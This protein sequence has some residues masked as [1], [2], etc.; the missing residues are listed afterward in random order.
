M[1]QVINLFP[2]PMFHAAIAPRA[3]TGV[4]KAGWTSYIMRRF[5]LEGYLSN[6]E[7]Y[8]IT[9]VGGVP[10][11][12]IAMIMSP[13]SKK[14]SLKAARAGGSGAA[15]LGKGPQARF[16]ALMSEG[17]PFTQVWGMVGHCP[18]FC[19]EMSTDIA[20]TS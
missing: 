20:A 8:A 10:P 13:L 4:L 3:H 15:P 1:K 12:I 17:A 11:M 6:C 14:Y 7:K 16:Q 19:P 2:L 18:K 9:E 5:D